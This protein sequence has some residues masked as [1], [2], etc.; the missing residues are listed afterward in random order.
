M[1]YHM[2]IHDQ[3]FLLKEG[4]KG[5]ALAAI[6]L[7]DPDKLGRGGRWEKGKQRERWFSWVDTDEYRS[8]NT[9]EEALVAWGWRS[10]VD[11]G[12]DIGDIDNLAFEGEKKGQDEILFAAIAPFVEEGSYVTMMGEDMDVW[13]WFFVDGKCFAQY[14]E[15]TFVFDQEGEEVVLN[16]D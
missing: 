13:R 7:L 8:A 2:N 15:M 1:G 11:D 12:A 3:D 9:L 5:K 6:K 14:A 16:A 10:Y 4:N